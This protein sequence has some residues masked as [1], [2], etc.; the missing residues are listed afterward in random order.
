MTA[1][2][3]P[4]QSLFLSIHY[5]R[6]WWVVT[7]IICCMKIIRTL[8]ASFLQKRTTQKKSKNVTFFIRNEAFGIY[9]VAGLMHIRHSLCIFWTIS[10]IVFLDQFEQITKRHVYRHQ[11]QNIHNT[12]DRGEVTLKALMEILEM[13]PRRSVDQC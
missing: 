10:D 11:T 3:N 6:F 7:E 2:T 13:N 1:K 9:R 5:K 12:T 8:F 4:H